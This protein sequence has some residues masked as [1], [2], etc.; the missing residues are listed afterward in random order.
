MTVT[1]FF[2]TIEALGFAPAED[3]GIT[4][5]ETPEPT[6]ERVNV[7]KLVEGDEI[8]VPDTG[9]W[10]VVRKVEIRGYPC[11]N[12]TVFIRAD[13]A[14]YGLDSFPVTTDAM[15]TRTTR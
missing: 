7:R 4:V 15:I 5:T 12:A 6:T 11:S 14:F 2:A 10:G 3:A 8:Q 9:R 13:W 1:D